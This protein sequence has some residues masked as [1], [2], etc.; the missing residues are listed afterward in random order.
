MVFGGWG[1]G[2]QADFRELNIWLKSSVRAALSC[3][4]AVLSDTVLAIADELTVHELVLRYKV[5]EIARAVERLAHLPP[6]AL[7]A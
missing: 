6:I 5:D 2:C 3:W 7:A 4:A 1:V